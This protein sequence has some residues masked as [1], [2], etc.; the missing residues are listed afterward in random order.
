M[1]I[2]N[3]G[4]NAVGNFTI[5]HII[6][7]Q[8]DRGYDITNTFVTLKINEGITDGLVDG[9]LTIID[10]V[11]LTNA[12]HLRGDERI[13]VSFFS[14]TLS[15]YNAT[16]YKKEFRVYHVEYMDDPNTLA[17]RLV[18]IHFASLPEVQN[19]FYRVSKSYN[20][21]GVDAIV[22]DMLKIIGVPEGDM[23]IESTLYNK[24]IV[25]P[26]LT[27]LE[28]ITYLTETAQSGNNEANGDS[29][30]YFFEDR[31]FVW[32]VSG[33]TLAKREPI[34]ELIFEGT[35][36]TYMYNKVIN[37]ARVRGYNLY[38]Q[39]RTGGLGSTV[40]S[41]SLVNKSYKSVYQ[42]DD[43]I[44]NNFPRINAEKWYGGE[45]EANRDAHVEFRSEDQMY[46]FLNVGSRGNAAAIR[47][48]NRAGLNA[49]RALAVIPGNTDITAGDIIDLKVIKT[50]ETANVTDSGKWLV[51]G[52]V[53][54]LTR[55]VFQTSLELI[56]D[57]DIRRA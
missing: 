33:T 45:M 54:I 9:S 11:N 22:K 57:S 42:S 4:Y 39:L 15:G 35:S 40:H 44:K 46:Q 34:A 16:A 8:G 6:I 51:S 18:N 2:N 31:D 21:A 43:E 32:F 24:D 7:Q 41:H 28:V 13:H 19:E 50:T 3:K 38:D 37:F 10:S 49:K 48:V 1:A 36:D 5:D 29:N 26:N 23:S 14:K 47:S 30:F 52:C 27:P 56:S 12:L 53:H 25:I 55:E 17:R 20:G